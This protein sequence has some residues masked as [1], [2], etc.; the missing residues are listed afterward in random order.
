MSTVSSVV[1]VIAPYERQTEL[2]SAI[3]SVV[4]KRP[5]VSES[6]LW[7]MTA[8]KMCREKDHCPSPEIIAGTID[9]MVRRGLMLGIDYDAG[10]DSNTLLFPI[11]TSVKTRIPIRVVNES[12]TL[13]VVN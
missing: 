7:L 4:Q 12:P 1:R 11:G 5:G 9:R 13:G 6:D 10:D 3:L 8:A 2:E